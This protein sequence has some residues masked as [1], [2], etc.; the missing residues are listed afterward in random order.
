[1]FDPPIVLVVDD[2]PDMRW[3]LA[4]LFRDHGYQ[5]LEAEDGERA[6]AVAVE[7]EPQLVVSDVRMPKTDGVALVRRLRERQ[8]DLPVILL[9]AVEDLDTAVG[10]MKQGAFDYMGKPFDADRLLV[11]AERAVEQTRLRREVVKLR[12]RLAS[13]TVRFGVSDAAAQI[14]RMIE[15]VAPQAT[16]S[17][18]ISGES[19]TGKEV[20]AREIHR[21][22]PVRD[23]PFVA[24][25][26][27]ALPEPLMESQLFGHRKGAF[28]GAD[29]DRQGLFRRAHGG[30][31]F[32]DELGN[33][34]LSLQA[35][36]LRALQ[37]R[38]VVP[39]GGGEPEPFEA[40]LLCATNARLLEDVR[41]ERFRVDLYHR[42]AEIAIEIPPLRQR[43]EDVAHFARLFLAEANAEMGR[44][45]AGLDAA[46]EAALVGH[47]WPGNLRELRNAIRRAVVL[48][49][50][51]MLDA[52]GL[53]VDAAAATVLSPETPPETRSLT[54][55]IRRATEA[56]EA[57]ILEETLAACTGN[58]AAAAR[59]LE[60]D[61]TTLHR[62]LKR[63]G[64]T[65][66]T[67][68]APSPN[69]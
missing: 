16:I 15:L 43:P 17:V 50:G 13:R 63:H 62:K 67:R 53:G 34:P 14:E 3:V 46:A 39:V 48:C 69:P 25:D 20:V 30:T 59:A 60:I 8:P 4:G 57:R 40:R 54:E 2:E 1:M 33:L 55:R 68:T 18:L 9:S 56:L 10:A 6:F 61:Y 28:T 42:V 31:L 32:L 52:N 11:T 37:E 58:K 22:S 21:R 47:D 7:Q 51:D 5:V 64:L 23:G 65:E 41:A 45:I 24:V 27:G 44:Q 26:C 38:A 19:G 36:L 49:H 66:A 35:K 12:D 29:R